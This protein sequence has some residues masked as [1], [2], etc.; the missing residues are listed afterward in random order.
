[1]GG[2]GWEVAVAGADVARG[3]VERDEDEG[4]CEVGEDMK[5]VMT[6]KSGMER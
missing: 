3:V 6:R 5:S 4:M 1:M 2:E